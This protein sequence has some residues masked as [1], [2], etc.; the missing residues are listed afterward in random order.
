MDFSTYFHALPQRASNTSEA[1]FR[2]LTPQ[3]QAP[4]ITARAQNGAN[5]QKEN[6]VRGIST[7]AN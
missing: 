6:I 2:T 4:Y 7:S 5:C 3:G 1:S